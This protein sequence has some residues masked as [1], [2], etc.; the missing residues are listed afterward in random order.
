MTLA[1]K[2][3][4]IFAYFK[5]LKATINLKIGF[6]LVP[7]KNVLQPNILFK[8]INGKVLWWQC[9]ACLYAVMVQ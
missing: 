5:G 9:E 4:S 6:N 3:R 8:I 2:I 7:L 1:N